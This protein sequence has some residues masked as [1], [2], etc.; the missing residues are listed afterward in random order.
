MTDSGQ[1]RSTKFEAEDELDFLFANASPNPNREGCPSREELR[2]VSRQK[3]PIGD[4]VYMHIVRCSPCFREMRALQQARARDR[5]ARMSTVGA[6]AVVAL[7]AGGSWWMLRS[8]HVN[9]TAVIATTLDLR[10][11]IVMRGD[12]QSEQPPPVVIPRGRLD[13]TILLPLGAE[14]GLYEVQLLD[15]ALSVRATTTGQADILDSVTTLRSSLNTAAVPTGAYQL[16]IQRAG[17]KA[18][19]FP[20]VLE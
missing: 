20:A 15:K 19:G 18:R 3:K 5:K 4:P 17:G 9:N 10:P 13:A 11:F 12:T 1:P 2:R 6:A 16:E 14:P 7:I 8:P